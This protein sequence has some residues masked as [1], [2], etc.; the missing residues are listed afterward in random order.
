MFR[1]RAVEDKGTVCRF[2]I[3]A[4]RPSLEQLGSLPVYRPSHPIQ[5]NLR[6][7]AR[8]SAREERFFFAE[9]QRDGGPGRFLDRFGHVE[10][11]VWPHKSLSGELF[12]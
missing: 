7:S 9:F 8:K 5:V 11:L 4:A 10:F 12:P 2:P 1:R 3:L 6:E